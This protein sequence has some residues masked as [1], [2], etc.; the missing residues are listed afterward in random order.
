MIEWLGGKYDPKAFNTNI[1]RFDNPKKR[2]KNAF[3]NGEE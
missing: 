2:W 1:V 3:T